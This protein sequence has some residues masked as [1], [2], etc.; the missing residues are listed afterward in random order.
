MLIADRGGLQD[1][2][3]LRAIDRDINRE[4]LIETL[5][6]LSSEEFISSMRPSTRWLADYE[7]DLPSRTGHSV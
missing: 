5:I 1:A 7:L 6:N 3:S 2:G 4:A